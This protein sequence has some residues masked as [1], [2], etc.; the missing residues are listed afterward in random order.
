MSAPPRSH[1][2]SDSQRADGDAHDHLVGHMSG[3]CRGPRGGAAQHLEHGP[4]ALE[5]GGF[6]AG[7]DGQRALLGAHGAARDRRVQM[8]H[9]QGGEACRVVARLARLDGRHVHHQRARAQ[10]WGGA[11]LEQHVFHDLAVFQQGDH[12][13]GLGHG[14][15][16]CVLHLGAQRQQALGFG[17]RAVPGVHG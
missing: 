16:R 1:S 10:A 11:L 17:A 3:L 4:C 5:V 9:A 2:S 8:H 13:I 14:L 6:A 7:H 15:G 12:H